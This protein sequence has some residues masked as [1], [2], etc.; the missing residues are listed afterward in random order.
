[1]ACFH[2]REA[3]K[4]L[5][6]GSLF[7]YERG[8]CQRIEIACGQCHGCRL[9]RARHWAVRCVHE[10]SLHDFNSFVTLTYDDAHVPE[11]G[12]R[13]RD[14]QLFMKRVR[15]RFR[16]RVRF[17][18]CGEYGERTARPHFHALLFGVH[19]D[20]RSYWRKTE[21]GFDVF[22]SKILESLWSEGN[23][24]IGEVTF[25][26]AGYVA[27]YVHKKVTGPRAAAHY[28]RLD[29]GTGEIWSLTPEFCRMSLKPGIGAG[30]LEKFRSDVFPR[31]YVVIRGVKCPVPRYYDKLNALLSP[32]DFAE[33]E[34]D[35]A[36]KALSMEADCTPA[37][38]A[39]R[40]VVAVARSNL[41]KRSL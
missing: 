20:D 23:S 32:K 24:E 41:K 4:P 9:E 12:L 19:F 8:D 6:G 29:S 31:D 34:V 15:R 22:R 18:M 26:S 28:E 5:A 39:V 1:M 10:A 30:W 37:R 21:V 27:G 33:V 17:F 35:R 13:Y 16:L 38:L 36:V 7:W 11:R 40:E 25:E 2:P 14:F 3:W